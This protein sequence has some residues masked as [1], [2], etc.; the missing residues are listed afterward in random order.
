MFPITARRSEDGATPIRAAV[1]E[2][3]GHRE[4]APQRRLIERREPGLVARIRIGPDVYFNAIVSGKRIAE[5]CECLVDW[6]NVRRQSRA[7]LFGL[8]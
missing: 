2:H 8:Q 1:D 5:A 7:H 4:L 3:L 6:K